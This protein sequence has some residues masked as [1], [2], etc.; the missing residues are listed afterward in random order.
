MNLKEE[1]RKYYEES[2][3]HPS[4]EQLA[5]ILKI[6]VSDLKKTDSPY[7]KLI[8][9]AEK[10]Y[11]LSCLFDTQRKDGAMFIL[12]NKFN[13]ENQQI[14]HNDKVIIEIVKKNVK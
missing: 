13:Y 9:E 5:F 10:Q 8:D 2:G 3:L 7:L 4:L 12:K 14:D 11:L 1:L 6:P